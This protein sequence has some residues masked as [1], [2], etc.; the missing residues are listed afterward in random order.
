M[1]E[2][3]GTGR[4]RRCLVVI[5]ALDPD[6]E[7]ANYAA[8]LLAEGAEQIVAVDDGSGPDS[9]PVFRTLEGM[10]G[11]TVLRHERNQGK[12]R[13]MKDAFA[14]IAAQE[15]WTGCAVVTGRTPTGSTGWRTYAPWG[16]PPWRR[17]TGWCWACGI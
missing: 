15:R 9:Q 7:L 3:T 10:E 8:A 12:G 13:A 5:P 6:G 2:R 11:C 16:R 1:G 4:L 14:W 17:R